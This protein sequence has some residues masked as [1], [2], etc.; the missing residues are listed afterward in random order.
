MEDRCIRTRVLLAQAQGVPLRLFPEN[1]EGLLAEEVQ[2]KHEKR[3]PEGGG[4]GVIGMDSGDGVGVRAVMSSKARRTAGIYKEA[5]VET[6]AV[7][8]L[9]LRPLTAFPLPLL[10]ITVRQRANGSDIR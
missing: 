1:T 10:S 4:T 8:S 2:R 7:V 5:G 6:C 9:T 3:C